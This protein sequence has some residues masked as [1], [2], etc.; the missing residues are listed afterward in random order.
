M[1]NFKKGIGALLI[2]SC[3]AVMSCGPT[4]NNNTMDDSRRNEHPID[5]S[6]LTK[7]DTSTSYISVP[8]LREKYSKSC[9]KKITGKESSGI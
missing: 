9:S 5:S 8:E 6:R 2:A 7:S 1:K 4:D 3:V